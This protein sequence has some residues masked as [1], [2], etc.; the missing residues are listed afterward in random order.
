MKKI[1]ITLLFI[2]IIPFTV[3]AF[4][5]NSLGLK[6][7]ELDNATIYTREDMNDSYLYY[8]NN[9]YAQAE[10]DNYKMYIRAIDNPIKKDYTPNADLTD[11]VF[12]LIENV[13]TNEYSFVETKDYKWIRFIYKTKDSNI[14][15][16]E[17]YLSYKDIFVTITF[18]SKNNDFSIN[19][20]R[21]MEDFIKSITL[22]GKGKAEVSHIYLDGI[23]TKPKTIKN[24]LLFEIIGCVIAVGITYFVTRKN[25]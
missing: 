17:Y 11:D 22:T 21:E 7:K 18:Q 23:D 12:G 5:I 14:P 16:T 3:N 25:N 24:F 1:L 19:E 4:E 13:N 6:G 15:L 9:L 10:N 8:L 2:L 20:K